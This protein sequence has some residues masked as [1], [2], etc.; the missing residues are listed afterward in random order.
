MRAPV[1]PTPSAR[2]ETPVARLV[3]LFGRLGLSR[4]QARAWGITGGYALFATLW[5]YF[6][7][8]A[9]RALGFD[10]AR[11]VHGELYKGLAFVAVTSGLLLLLLRR[12]LRAI[13]TWYGSYRL[14]EIELER[15]KRLYAALSHI[16]HAIVRQP[17]RNELFQRICRVLVEEGGF[18]L[19]WIGWHDAATHRLVPVAVWGDD[20][21]YI[22]TIQVY[23]DDRPEGRGPSGTAF[24]ENR[25]Y[26]CNDMVNDPAT[27]PWR[28]EVIRRGFRASAVLP[29]R[30]DD[31]VE[32][33]LAVY[34]DEVGF[35]RDKEVAL[36]TE[37]AG[38]IAF[39]LANLAREASRRAAEE[40]VRHERDF[41]DAVLNSLP[42]VLYLY[43]R[44]GRFLRWNR[45]FERVTGFTSGEI[46]AMHPLE[47]FTGPD[48]DQVAARIGEVFQR[49]ESS[50]EAGFVAKD[51]R[52]TPYY[53]TGIL[54]QL[55]GQA[56][57]VGV[58]IDI[59]E[60][61]RA[62][63]AKGASEARYQT[64]FAY[65]P[66]GIL[67]AD[68]QSVYLDANASIC[69]MLGYERHELIGL[70]AANIVAPAEF[71]EIGSALN[72]IKASGSDYGREWQFRRKD[73]SFFPAEVIATVMPDGNL[74]AMIRDITER[75]VAE[76]ALRELN[77]TLELKVVE[78]TGE[79]QSALV[80]AESADRI[81]SAFLAT[82]S[83][84][85]RTPL[86]SI[87]GFTGIVLQELAGPLNP[88]QAKQLGMVRGSARHLL[89]LIND[90]LDLSKI[91]A[92]QLEVGAEPFDLRASIAR[93]IASIRPQAEKKTSRWTQPWPPMWPGWWAT[94]GAWSRSSSIF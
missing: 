89:E 55:A 43:D 16:S 80:R 57:L 72:A 51:G 36:L 93:A 44:S 52:A 81:K 26:I 11:R 45:N 87:I 84:E 65:A 3:S 18:R 62:E 13:K 58:G 2:R 42:G 15:F 78:R 56:C 41:S 14:R 75:K 77:E 9:L 85:L 31:R 70:H 48:R 66:D 20:N 19:A 91:E 76:W 68:T 1:I 74:L 69:R 64:L 29:I 6:S 49:G 39:A 79:L 8:D 34:A 17:D 59:S 7:D 53:F 63:A 60:R 23:A 54:A 12:A 46:A 37:V 30:V 83:H 10:P 4:L 94:A 73:G 5:V 90:V 33:T 35:F 28:T 27:L 24:R 92:G 22:K 21:D 25:P 38:D 61:R 71:P 40:A 67:I 82:M 88:E 50:V 86:N 32:G 47:F